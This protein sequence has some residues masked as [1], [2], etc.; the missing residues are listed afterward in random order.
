MSE[1]GSGFLRTHSLH[2]LEMASRMDKQ[3][4]IPHPDGYGKREGTCGDTVEVFLT[5]SDRRIRSV[6]FDTD[7]CIHTRA[8]CNTLVHLA[9][10]KT[11]AEVWKITPDDIVNYLETLP[12]DH[13]HC[14]ELTI[15]AF[16]LA[17][18][19]YKE[20]EKSPWKKWYQSH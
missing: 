8:C 12:A 14:A 4:I 11:I 5:V 17:L 15:G 16:Y 19:N 9:E 2:F 18:A 20:M 1:N 10:G 6:S 3:K 7:G 13:I